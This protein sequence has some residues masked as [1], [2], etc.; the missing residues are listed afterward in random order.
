MTKKKS[1]KN[2]LLIEM[3]NVHHSISIAAHIEFLNCILNRWQHFVSSKVF[4]FVIFDVQ[5]PEIEMCYSV[6]DFNI[7]IINWIRLNNSN[8]N[9]LMSAKPCR[10]SFGN[11]VKLFPDK[12]RICSVFAKPS[13][14]IGEMKLKPQWRI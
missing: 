13:N 4:Q 6:N 12:S 9:Y 5:H 11:P 8:I 7:I 2:F 1:E 14:E 3:I 10:K